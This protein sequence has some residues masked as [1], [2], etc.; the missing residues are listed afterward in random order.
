M[1]SHAYQNGMRFV[2]ISENG[3]H[4]FE[5]IGELVSYTSSTVTYKLS[6]GMGHI[7]DWK[8]KH[9]KQLHFPKQKLETRS[10]QPKAVSLPKE[11]NINMVFSSSSAPDS[12]EETSI[13]GLSKIMASC[14]VLMHMY[15]TLSKGGS[16]TVA[17][18]IAELIFCGLYGLAIYFLLKISLT[19]LSNIFKAAIGLSVLVFAFF[20]IMYLIS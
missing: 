10:Y 6:E 17:D 9:I 8:G 2:V 18:I 3:D 15:S 14:L 5:R 7:V 12:V 19:F 4:L 20:V 11:D 1:I 16:N 13:D